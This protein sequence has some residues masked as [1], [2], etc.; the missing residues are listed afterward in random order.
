MPSFDILETNS[1]GV[2]QWT[3][4]FLLRLESRSGFGKKRQGTLNGPE[5]RALSS[6]TLALLLVELPKQE[7]TR[8]NELSVAILKFDHLQRQSSCFLL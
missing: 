5:E 4:F 3:L 7:L 6:A 2:F 1:L 8:G